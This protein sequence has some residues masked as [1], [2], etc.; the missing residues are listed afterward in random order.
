MRRRR[1]LVLGLVLLGL[2]AVG[3]AA[4]WGAGRMVGAWGGGP[5][6]MWRMMATVSGGGLPPGVPA[7]LLPEPGSPGAALLETYCTQCHGLPGPGMHTA[8]EWPAVV[9]RMARRMEMMAGHPMMRVR[10]PTQG[11]LDTIL[12]YL[13]RHAQSPIERGRYPDLDGPEGRAFQATCSQ[14]H[15]LPDPRRHTAAEWPAVVARMKGNMAAMGK[16]VPDEAET[17]RILRFLQRHARD[18]S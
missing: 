6:L 16:A 12:A 2:G 9:A 11:E 7:V 15:V 1:D 5:G 4:V 14:C 13:Q 3:L 10:A 17:A 8:A 18:A